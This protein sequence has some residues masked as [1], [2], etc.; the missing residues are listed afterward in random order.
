MNVLCLLTSKKDIV[1]KR[2]AELIPIPSRTNAHKCCN[3]TVQGKTAVRNKFR[4]PCKVGR[5]IW[6]ERPRVFVQKCTGNVNEG[7]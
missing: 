3:S 4:Q 1:F 6:K 5:S 7:Q 2:I